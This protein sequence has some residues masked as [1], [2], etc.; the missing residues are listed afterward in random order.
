MLL[1]VLPLS[2]ETEESLGCISILNSVGQSG[3]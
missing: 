3:D 2:D 1:R